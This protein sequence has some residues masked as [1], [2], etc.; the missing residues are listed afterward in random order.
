MKPISTTREQKGD[1]YNVPFFN[2]NNHE[3]ILQ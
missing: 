1:E 2:I 3:I